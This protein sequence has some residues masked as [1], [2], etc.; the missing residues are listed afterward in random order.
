MLYFISLRFLNKIGKYLLGFIKLNLFKILRKMLLKHNLIDVAFYEKIT[1]KYLILKILLY[2]AILFNRWLCRK[3]DLWQMEIIDNLVAMQVGESILKLDEADGVF[4]V[5]KNSDLFMRLIREK[6][7]EP[8]L[9][10]FCKKHLDQSKDVIDVGANIGF[11]TVMLAKNIGNQRILAIEPTKGALRL[12]RK[13]IELNNVG[14]KVEVFDGVV[15]DFNGSVQIKTIS[16]K[17]EFSSIGEMSHPS[18]SDLKWENEEVK[19]IKLDDLV[20]QK[21]INPGFIKIDVEGSEHLVFTGAK[22]ILSNFR[23]IIL[24][25]LND[26]MLKKN[27]SSA[28]EVID[29]I[30]SFNYNV[31]D[32]TD[33]STLPGSKDFG[34]IV[35]FPKE[36]VIDM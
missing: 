7:Y 31:Y 24:S 14:D 28:K 34:D 27:G 36:I 32:A 33:F 6:H 35:C 25:E 13:N 11:Y 21:S 29:L 2:P 17:E 9:M 26:I 8:H 20:E 12:L 15:S 22:N 30:E 19:S 1:K 18:I 5:N 4:A 10:A 16:G 23:P 3:K